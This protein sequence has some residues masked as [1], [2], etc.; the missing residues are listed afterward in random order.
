VSR[1]SARRALAAGLGVVK[2]DPV[3]LRAALALEKRYLRLHLADFIKL[4]EAKPPGFRRAVEEKF[5]RLL[6]RRKDGQL[7][8]RVVHNT[9][10]P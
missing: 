8:V 9:K 2:D 6:R 1:V 4:W 5:E 7:S 10:G 3:C